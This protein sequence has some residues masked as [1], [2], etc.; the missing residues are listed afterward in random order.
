MKSIFTK[1]LVL[2]VKLNILDM[3]EGNKNDTEDMQEVSIDFETLIND[4]RSIAFKVSQSYTKDYLLGPAPIVVYEETTSENIN[5]TIIL[6]T[7][8]KEYILD[9]TFYITFDKNL[10]ALSIFRTNTILEIINDR[11]LIC[12]IYKLQKT[13]MEIEVEA[14][15]SKP[16]QGKIDKNT[17][18]RLLLKLAGEG[19]IKI[20]KVVMSNDEKFRTQWIIAHPHVEINH[21]LFKATQE[22]LVLKFFLGMEKVHKVSSKATENLLKQPP[23]LPSP[24]D[25]NE[26]TESLNMLKEISDTK[27]SSSYK[28]SRMFGRLLGFQP[29]FVRLQLLHEL[30][31]YLIYDYQPMDRMS[32]SDIEEVLV[33]YAPEEFH[34]I[35]PIYRRGVDWKMFIPPLPIHK[36]WDNGWAL[37]C[38]VILAIPL[39]LWVKLF[40]T[41]LECPELYAYM[42]H[43]VRK[44]YLI[45]DIPL[46]FR[47][48]IMFKRKYLPNA[49]ELLYR[50][51]FI[52]LVQLGPQNTQVKDQIF[53]YLNRRTTLYDTSTSAPSYHKVTPKN[54]KQ[55]SFIFSSRN[56][57]EAYWCQ[58]WTISMNTPL[59]QRT[60]ME[61]K[62]VT[63]ENPAY[64]TV[65]L[66]ALKSKTHK[67][68]QDDD[69][70]EIPGD[71]QGAAGLDSSMWVHLK[72]NWLW[73]SKTKKQVQSSKREDPN[74]R[75]ANIACIKPVSIKYKELMNQNRKTFLPND[76]VQ[77]Q[78]LVTV[79]PQRKREKCRVFQRKVSFKK[80]PKQKYALDSK[81][82]SILKKV[83]ISFRAAWSRKEDSLLIICKAASNF[84]S[85]KS[86]EQ[87]IPLSIIRDVLHSL[88]PESKDKTT[89]ACIRRIV[90][91]SNVDPVMKRI[92][93]NSRNLFNLQ[94][95]SKYFSP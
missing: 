78:K 16:G 46:E 17:L 87:I 63:I 9:F 39:S 70:G 77:F 68:A 12:D 37:L 48:V 29:K 5:V 26:I 22:Q 27:P 54:Y 19:Y 58:L 53:L 89:G 66:D 88:C 25:S 51:C 45:K 35:P 41:T 14:P 15:G 65:L 59:G 6:S 49:V 80:K 23:S 62:S 61:G 84:L 91:L 72:R 40:N 50:L 82:K 36:E 1:S 90:K 2:G 11:T 85:T 30:L 47:H 83:G 7:P 75:D 24:F 21:P 44:H 67:Q 69:T 95:I 64:K 38:D 20:F 32:H 43:P 71:K 3:L 13:I 18:N 55:I 92:K 52:G 74:I 10:T 33:H 31:Y 28:I 81:D 4:R 57:V 34:D 8:P 73:S 93:D 86:N 76:H 60:V 56:N 94:E 42:E 79:N